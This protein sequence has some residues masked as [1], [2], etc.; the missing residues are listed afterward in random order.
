MLACLD[1]AL[2][3]YAQ[4]VAWRRLQ[5]QAMGQDFGWQASAARYLALYREL[6]PLAPQVSGE[7]RCSPPTSRRMRFRRREALRRGLTRASTAPHR[8][9]ARAFPLPPGLI[10]PALP[11][12][13]APGE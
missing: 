9:F 2:D 7:P 12:Q 5:R 8:A 1:R 4:P 10:R 6:A 13:Y 3:A 11:H